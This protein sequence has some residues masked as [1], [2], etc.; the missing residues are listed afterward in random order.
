MKATGDGRQAE[1]LNQQG[2]AVE[3]SL[4]KYV[5]ERLGGLTEMLEFEAEK[6]AKLAAPLRFA[7]RFLPWPIVVL[8]STLLLLSG[9]L[10]FRLWSLDGEVRELR[11]RVEALTK[12]RGTGGTSVNQGD[13]ADPPPPASADEENP[14]DTRQ[15]T[16]LQRNWDHFLR[17][18]SKLAIRWLRALENHHGLEAKVVT[19]EVVA[20]AAL[21]ID[22]LERNEFLSV[23][24]LIDSRTALFQYACALWSLERPEPF[25][26]QKNYCTS[27]DLGKSS[28]GDSHLDALYRAA[29]V[30]VSSY[31]AANAEVQI[32][33]AMGWMAS[34]SVPGRPR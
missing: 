29:G 19:S 1:L 6:E 9:W 13:S 21:W 23:D 3:D 24:E 5:D 11:A 12:V 14:A 2:Q 26:S 15:L 32:P 34:Q 10:G 18:N 22:L 17:D 31:K 16:D 4:R 20:E 7:K 27:V 25:A 8:L 30:T 33:V 28:V